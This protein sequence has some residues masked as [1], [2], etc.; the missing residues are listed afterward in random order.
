MLTWLP[1][2]VN[3]NLQLLRYS[4]AFT[5]LNERKTK[6]IVDESAPAPDPR[7]KAKLR[8]ALTGDS[9]RDPGEE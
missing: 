3:E 4:A 5:K 9:T 8:P 1:L 7:T 6:I 2:I